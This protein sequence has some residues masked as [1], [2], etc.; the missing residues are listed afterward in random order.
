MSKKWVF[1]LHLIQGFNTKNLKSHKLFIWI[2]L[3]KIDHDFEY[4]IKNIL[5]KLKKLIYMLNINQSNKYMNICLLLDPN[6][7]LFNLIDIQVFRVLY[8]EQIFLKSC[9]IYGD[10]EHIF[11]IFI[12]KLP[13]S[14]C[15]F[16]LNYK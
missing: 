2:N 9:F 12:L 11:V 15:Y 16:L 8:F 7:Y 5:E 4:E 3:S 1:A 13:K 10:H 6:Q 14:L